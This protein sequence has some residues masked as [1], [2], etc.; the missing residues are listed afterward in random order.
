MSDASPLSDAVRPCNSLTQCNP[1]VAP[2]IGGLGALL[3]GAVL[4]AIFFLVRS[5]PRGYVVAVV[6][7]VHTANIAD[8]LGSPGRAL[9]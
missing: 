8:C 3:A 1:L 5:R 2:V 9:C 6:D 7:V 4:V